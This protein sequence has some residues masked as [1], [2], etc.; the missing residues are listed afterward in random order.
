MH[1]AEHYPNIKELFDGLIIP[2]ELAVRI[3][4][5]YEGG[6][7]EY[8]TIARHT[9]GRIINACMF[10]DMNQSLE[11]EIVDAIFNVL[12]CRLRTDPADWMKLAKYNVILTLLMRAHKGV[13]D[14]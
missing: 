3:K 1:V 5:R 2:F 4:E 7:D 9:D 10:N 13:N 12:V 14:L 6:K 8:A 11:E